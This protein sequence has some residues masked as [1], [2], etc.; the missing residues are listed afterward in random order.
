ML[1]SIYGFVQ[2]LSLRAARNLMSL[3]SEIF[4]FLDCI[5][6]ARS[7]VVYN[8]VDLDTKNCAVSPRS[9]RT[10][11]FSCLLLLI[12]IPTNNGI[13]SSIRTGS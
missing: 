6:V 3:A 12:L 8:C 5:L 11:V 9:V 7:S 13:K 2:E 1:A 10:L 4:V